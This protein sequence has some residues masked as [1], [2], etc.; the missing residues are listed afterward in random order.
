MISLSKRFDAP[1]VNTFRAILTGRGWGKN[2]IKEFLKQPSK[3]KDRD[4]EHDHKMMPDLRPE[5]W[6][7][8]W[9]WTI[10]SQSWGSQDAYAAKR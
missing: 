2:R 7:G 4:R 3:M 10:A 1:P 8:P 9:A 6:V 5:P